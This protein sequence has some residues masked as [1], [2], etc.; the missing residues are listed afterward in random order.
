MAEMLMCGLG[1]PHKLI[2][3][4]IDAFRGGDYARIVGDSEVTLGS[5]VPWAVK[6]ECLSL[7]A[8]SPKHALN[9]S[10]GL[11]ACCE[12]DVVLIEPEE[13]AGGTPHDSG[14]YDG[15]Q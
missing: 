7:R 14:P 5:T 11:L 8:Q 2:S 4:S 12:Y 15:C 9:P 3:L 13:N 1:E 6:Q 10:C